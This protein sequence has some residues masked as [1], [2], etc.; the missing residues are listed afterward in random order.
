MGVRS[1]LLAEAK[2]AA[3]PNSCLEALMTERYR[4]AVIGC[5]KPRS[6][7][8]ATGFGMAHS[9]VHGYL[10]TGRC[11]LAAVADVVPENARDFV[12]RYGGAA[13]VYTDY[14]EMLEVERPDIVSICTWPKLHAPMVLA[15]AS[16]DVRAIHCEKPMAPTW[17][18][19]RAMHRAAV[20]K[21]IQLTF[22]HQRRFLEPFQLAR[23]L[24][25]EGVIGE[26]RR[27][28]ASCP[29]LFDWGTHWL[30][31]F[32]FY[33]D[34][35]PARWVMGQIDCREPQ[36]IFGVPVENQ[37]LCQV[38]FRNDVR[39]L[40]F[41]GEDA[42]IGCSN[43]LVGTEGIIEV[44]PQQ[45]HVRVRGRGDATWRLYETAEGLH[46]QVAIDRGIADLIA[47]LENGREPELS[48]HKALR[49][50]EVIFATYESSRRRGRID[51]PLDAEDSALLSML[52]AGEIGPSRPD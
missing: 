22:N 3:A 24:L 1:R 38:R 27:M 45:P 20:Q 35:T 25:R 52:D 31:M 46:E 4:V 36:S 13:K 44:H 30:D 15:A 2:R 41:T 16:A 34:E 28:E 39:A 37:A 7:R 17:G 29:N 51:L 14:Q 18:E 9:H 8:G 12:A 50:T 33:N 43:R 21:G 5:G 48:S 47:C 26:L 19:S 42:D 49:C 32:F 6:D 11:E 40:L 23:R 10:A